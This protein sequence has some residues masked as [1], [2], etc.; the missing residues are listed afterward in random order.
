MTQWANMCE[1]RDMAALLQSRRRNLLRQYEWILKLSQNAVARDPGS[2]SEWLRH[3]DRVLGDVIDQLDGA[4]V[5]VVIPARNRREAFTGGEAWRVHPIAWADADLMLFRMTISELA[6]P[7][8]DAGRSALATATLMLNQRIGAAHLERLDSYTKAMRAQADVARLTE[9][10]RLGR[11]IHD[12]LGHEIALA[13]QS[14]ELAD[15]YTLIDPAEADRRTRMAR[16]SLR[17]AMDE[18]RVVLAEL[19]SVTP[20]CIGEALAA[21]CDRLVADARVHVEMHGTGVC[22]PELV[23]EQSF[24]V[25]REALRNAVTHGTPRNIRIDIELAPRLLRASVE[26]DGG[27]FPAGPQHGPPIGSPIRPSGG[28]GLAAMRERAALVG[29]TLSVCSNT[30]QGTR[31]ELLVPL[32]EE[33]HVGE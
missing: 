33:R 18:M 30:G 4:D 23:R 16:D 6:G 27:G 10:L 15:M 29:G 13:H 21:E 1:R 25:L 26:D 19:R 3:A 11:E 7:G 28:I 12:R 14:L 32:T 17:G 20:V 8:D 22:A 5:P 24:L 9:R 2:L 31:V